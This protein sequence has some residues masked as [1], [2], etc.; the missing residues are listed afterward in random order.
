MGERESLL[1]IPDIDHPCLSW[2]TFCDLLDGLPW[3]AVE[4]RLPLFSRADK[5]SGDLCLLREQLTGPG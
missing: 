5:S 4:P 2:D 3:S 1:R